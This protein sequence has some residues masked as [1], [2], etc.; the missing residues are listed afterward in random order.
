MI[1]LLFRLFQKIE[2]NLKLLKEI[3]QKTKKNGETH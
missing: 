1:F 2:I 3:K